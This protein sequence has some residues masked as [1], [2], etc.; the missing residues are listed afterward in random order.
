MRH[1]TGIAMP[2]FSPPSNAVVAPSTVMLLPETAKVTVPPCRSYRL[3]Q[4]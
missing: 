4:C 2:S 1:P 3:A